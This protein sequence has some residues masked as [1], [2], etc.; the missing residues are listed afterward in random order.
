M[1]G[2]ECSGHPD[3]DTNAWSL[4]THLKGESIPCLESLCPWRTSLTGLTW[5]TY[6]TPL[7]RAEQG[8]MA[9]RPLYVL[10][11][12]HSLLTNNL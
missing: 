8:S 12:L 3:G 7:T 10:L 11:M 5:A 1:T 6:S 9:G 4:R 2:T